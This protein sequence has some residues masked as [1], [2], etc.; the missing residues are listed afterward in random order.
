MKLLERGV[1]KRFV[2]EVHIDVVRE[3]DVLK[4]LKDNNYRVDKVVSF[5]DVKKVVYAR[6]SV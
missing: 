2:I 1:I 3:E 5:G 6:Y 4:L